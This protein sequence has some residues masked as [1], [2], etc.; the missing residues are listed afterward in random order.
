VTGDELERAI[1]LL[2]ESQANLTAKLDQLE[3]T[4]GKLADGHDRLE[5]TV[6]RLA[7][8]AAVDRAEVRSAV[9]TMLSFAESMAGNVKLLTEAQI[10]TS[11]R[12]DHVETRLDSIER[13]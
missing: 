10:A 13:S 2:L 7:E 11:R 6:E 5:A 4:V 12:V 9:A 8:E 3:V 1:A